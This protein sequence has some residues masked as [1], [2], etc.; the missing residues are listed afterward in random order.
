MSNTEQAA[1]TEKY[2]IEQSDSSVTNVAKESVEN[3]E[4]DDVTS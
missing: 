4:I 3:V 2:I 1:N